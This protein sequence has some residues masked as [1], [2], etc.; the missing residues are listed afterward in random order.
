[1]E[2]QK[3]LVVQIISTLEEQFHHDL[4]REQSPGRKEGPKEGAAEASKRALWCALLSQNI[5]M[6]TINILY[7][8]FPF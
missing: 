8:F 7:L 6:S 1:M 4:F 5:F 3:M 2:A